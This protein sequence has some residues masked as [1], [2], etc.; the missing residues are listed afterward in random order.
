MIVNALSNVVTFS[1]TAFRSG[2]EIWTKLQEK[3]G[4]SKFIGD[5]YIPSTSSGDELSSTS[6]TC[7]KTQGN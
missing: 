6:P 2:H 1:I 3:Y 7:G 5:G 4:V